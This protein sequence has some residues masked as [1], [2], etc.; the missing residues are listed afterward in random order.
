MSDYQAV[1]VR[2]CELCD[3]IEPHNHRYTLVPDDHGHSSKSP[4]LCERCLDDLAAII[5]ERRQAE[6]PEPEIDPETKRWISPTE[7]KWAE[8]RQARESEE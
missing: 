4:R 6:Q 2:G 1:A 3:R 7:K 8:E 5:R